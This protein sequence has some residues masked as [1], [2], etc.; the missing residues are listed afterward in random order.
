MQDDAVLSKLEK[1][2]N[3]MEAKIATFMFDFDKKKRFAYYVIECRYTRHIKWEVKRRY[4]QFERLIDALKLSFPGI[5][6]LPGKTLFSLTKD[7]A[8]EKRKESLNQVIF[9][10]IHREELYSHPHFYTFFGM[11]KYVPFLLINHPI[12]LGKIA[13]A[14]NMSYRDAFVSLEEEWALTGSHSIYVANRV[15]SYF[16]NFFSKKKT[17]VR[18]KAQVL[19]S[20]DKIVGLVEFLKRVDKNLPR[21][22]FEN[23][24]STDTGKAKALDNLNVDEDEPKKSESETENDPKINKT[25]DMIHAEE[26]ALGYFNY[27]KSFD[28][29]FKFQVI[30]LAWSKEFQQFAVGLDSGDIF[31][32]SYDPTNLTGFT[33]Q[34]TFLAAH[35]KRVMRL[36]FDEKKYNLYSIGEDKKFATIDLASEAII[37]RLVLPGG[38]LTDMIYNKEKNQCFVADNGN[39]IFIINL[40]KKYPE[41]FQKVNAQMK[42]PIRGLFGF[43]EH[44]CFVAS[45]HGD[46]VIKAFKNPSITDPNSQFFCI[47]NI[48]GPTNPRCLYYWADRK[49]LWVG[50]AKGIVSCYSN[51][52]LATATQI[53]DGDKPIS[54]PICNICSNV[55]SAAMHES[56]ITQIKAFPEQHMLLT[57][58]KDMTIRV[59]FI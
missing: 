19:K 24:Q 37:N 55:V 20:T 14:S 17:D 25:D 32:L 22:K 9:N 51:V 27:E 33:K 46:G 12:P 13:N 53:S 40:D 50:C 52:D 57:I 29:A 10:L 48:Q 2:Y 34:M 3:L 6:T 5:P 39:S 35:T 30:S 16:S 23:V 59:R 58:G 56:D 49:E 28:M 47:L 42:G 43:F 44:N 45:S 15:D 36:I 1:D 26:S 21:A 38:K 11:G 41:L 54:A 18:E 8:L 7:S 4:R 31:V